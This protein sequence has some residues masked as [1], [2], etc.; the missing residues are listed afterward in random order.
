[1]FSFEAIKSMFQDPNPKFEANLLSRKRLCNL[2]IWI[3]MAKKNGDCLST[4][5]SQFCS[6]PSLHKVVDQFYFLLRVTS[7]ICKLKSKHRIQRL[8]RA[9]SPKML[10]EMKR[11]RSETPA[12]N[13]NGRDG[14]EKAG[15][16][17]KPALG[18]H[19]NLDSNCRVRGDRESRGNASGGKGES[20]CRAWL[21]NKEKYNMNDDGVCR[22]GNVMASAMIQQTTRKKWP[23]DLRDNAMK[24]SHHRS[25][26]WTHKFGNY[27]SIEMLMYNDGPTSIYFTACCRLERTWPSSKI[28][29]WIIRLVKLTLTRCHQYHIHAVKSRWFILYYSLP[30]CYSPCSDHR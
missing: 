12:E 15:E 8:K 30:S 20:W 28:S 16:S 26:K 29:L 18:E 14:W 27:I 7:Q 6:R 11:T 13:A 25:R 22:H 9:E 10:R 19:K 24:H 1:M 17:S 3:M 5:S 21:K 4:S 2:E 23:H